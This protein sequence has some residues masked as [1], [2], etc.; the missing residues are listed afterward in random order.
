SV[1]ARDSQGWSNTLVATD[2]GTNFSTVSTMEKT[3]TLTHTVDGLV[4]SLQADGSHIEAWKQDQN[5]RLVEHSV[6]ER[7]TSYQ[8]DDR[9]DLIKEKLPTGLEIVYQRDKLSRLRN[10]GNG[11]NAGI[12][13]EYDDFGRRSRVTEPGGRSVRYA[14]DDFGRTA[15]IVT[16]EQRVELQYNSFGLISTVLL[17]NRGE[18]T[19]EYDDYDRLIEY[20]TNIDDSDCFWK[21]GY[22]DSDQLTS[23]TGPDGTRQSLEYDEV[24]RLVRQVSGGSTIQIGYDLQGRVVT[25]EED[26][27]TQ[28]I[29]YDDDGRPIGFDGLLKAGIQYLP[30]GI[31]IQASDPE[32]GSW[33]YANNLYGQLASI[34]NPLGGI[35]KYDRN[36]TGDLLAISDPGQR[37]LVYERD[38]LGR[39]VSFGPAEG[40]RERYLAD[41]S[42][43]LNQIVRPDGT[44]ISRETS[45]DGRRVV[46]RIDDTIH[47]TY[48]FDEL[49]KMVSAAGEF[50]V[51]RF[52]YDK[53]G[54]LVKATDPFGKVLT[55]QYP[56]TGQRAA[57]VGPQGEIVK[58]QYGTDGRVAEVI[59]PDAERTHYTRDATGRVTQ[60]D[61][62]GG[63][64]AT[65][66]Y[67]E[68]GTIAALQYSDRHQNSIA[69]RTFEADAR[70][71][72][73]QLGTGNTVWK[74]ESDLLG[75][76]TSAAGPGLST[77]RF[78]YD[79]S[80]NITRFGTSGNFVVNDYFQLE[81]IDDRPVQH[82]ANGNL[83]RMEGRLELDYDSFG[84]V[85]HVDRPN[86]PSAE[87]RYDVFGR[88]KETRT[89]GQTVRYLYD[90]NKLVAAYD[91]QG[92]RLA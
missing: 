2:L 9:G 49:G 31:T 83:T 85:T 19:F 63:A 34:T 76:L 20:R 30:D 25:I 68:H 79:G 53:Q 14:Y 17:D 65:V 72:L 35:T 11:D 89:A 15:E 67:T 45:Q 59:G 37:R 52:E 1:V 4:S 71:N 77:E 70:G 32:G 6:G 3:A 27:V 40:P 75:R 87:Y 12:E 8:Y 51:H 57:L 42:E 46:V 73:S 54:R 62:A 91:G 50:G 5:G 44:T 60:V 18:L 58:Y 81:S 28:S 47:A 56:K 90:G 36:Q 38:A 21:Y 88:L 64:T 10:I 29:A 33:H 39:L 24:G 43:T 84:H 55:Y 48:D 92:R 80:Q 16:G 23:I 66:A 61:L 41:K 78:Q 26:G 22:D 69:E 13:T 82:D 86:Q 74:F 7:S